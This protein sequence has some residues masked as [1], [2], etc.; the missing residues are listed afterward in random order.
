MVFS[1]FKKSEKKMPVRPAAPGRPSEDRTSVPA[2]VDDKV[3]SATSRPVAGLQKADLPF[4]TPVAPTDAP[5]LELSEFVFSEAAPEYQVEVDVDPIDAEAEEAAMLYANAQDRAV[6]MLLENSIHTHRNV[7]GE[8][9]WLM[10]FDFFRLTGQKAAFESLEIEY[11]QCYEK[12][13]PVWRDVAAVPARAKTATGTVLFKGELTADNDAAFDLLRQAVDKNTQL[14]VDLS[15]VRRVDGTGCER[16]LTI[17]SQARKGR[18]EVE[19]L[20]RDHL[21]ALLDA[22]VV[23]GAPENRG[24]WLLRLEFF[25]LRGEL[26]AFEELAINYAVTFEI[27]PPSWEPERVKDSGKE[28]LSITALDEVS[29]E[30]Y[31]IKGE[32][33]SSRFAD[34]LAYAAANDPVVIDCAAVTRMDF[35]SAGSLL[36]VLAT[37]KRTGREIIFR[38]PN[39]LVAELFRVV[40]LS[41]VAQIVLPRN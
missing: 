29:T 41:G 8:R 30:T 12:S 3:K 2:A 4:A 14:R 10:L 22:Q 7:A 37:V 26:E 35:V 25:Q 27:S 9:L 33:K 38:H 16:L 39:Y 18:R 36:N 28:P 31:V 20:N 1:F 17:L 6:R 11:A 40:G 24:C 15:K 23:A 5:P 21:T 19:L 32:V 34:L 13:P